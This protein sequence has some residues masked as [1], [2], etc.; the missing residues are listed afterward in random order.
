MKAP[1]YLEVR[2]PA[3]HDYRPAE[4]R[5]YLLKALADAPGVGLLEAFDTMIQ[6][7]VAVL[8]IFDE[9]GNAAPI[10]IVHNGR[11]EERLVPCCGVEVKVGQDANDLT[12]EQWDL[13]PCFVEKEK[14]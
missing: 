7:R 4:A 2:K 6:E 5:R 14:N 1:R 8:C 9:E 13:L 12:P 3:G 10:A 11:Y